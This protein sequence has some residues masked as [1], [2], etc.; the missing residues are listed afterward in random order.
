MS[1]FLRPIPSWQATSAFV[2]VCASAPDIDSDCRRH[3]SLSVALNGL[4][5]DHP[6][7]CPPQ[8]NASHGSM[9]LPAAGWFGVRRHRLLAP[10][11]VGRGHAYPLRLRTADLLNVFATRPEIALLALGALVAVVMSALEALDA[12]GHWL[13]FE[14]VSC[15]VAPAVAAV[16]VGIAARRGEREW[17]SFRIAIAASMALTATGQVIADLPD[18]GLTISALAPVSNLCNVGGAIIGVVTLVAT[19]GLSVPRE[20]RRSVVLD[21]LVILAASMTFVFANWIHQSLLPGG[22][23]VGAEFTNPTANLFLPILSTLFLA[24]A[25][26]SV[27]AALSMRVDPAYRGVWALA[28][29]ILLVALAWQGW[30]GRLISNQPDS[31]EIMDF[32]LPAGSILIGYGAAT[33]SLQPGGGRRYERIAGTIQDWLPIVAIVGCALLDVMPRSRPLALD[34]IAVGT[35]VV[36]LLA[37]GRYRLVLGKQRYATDRLATEQRER[38]ATTV[39]LLSLE[40]APTIE[41]TAERICTEAL[42]IEGIDT[43]VVFVFIGESVVPLALGGPAGRPCEVGVPLPDAA[44]CE[45][46]ECA[47]LGLWIESWVDREPRNDWDRA[48]ALSG[49]RAEAAVAMRW[50]D[51]LIGLLAMGATTPNHASHLQE[52]SPTLTEFSV[53]SAKLLGPALVE[54]TGRETVQ[55]EIKSIIADRKFHP[56]FQP[57]VE[58]ASG[59]HVG[60]EALARFDDGSRPDL[61]FQAADRVGMMV[62]LETAVLREQVLRARDLPEGTFVT[63]N[64][65]PTLAMAVIPLL[66]VLS[67]L[68]RPVVLEVTEHT[69]IKDYGRLAQALD[70]VRPIAGLAVDDAGA[71]YAG[72]RHIL[73]LRPQYVKLD[74]SLVRNVDADPARQAMVTGMAFFAENAGCALIAEGIETVNE[75]TALRL[76]GVQYGQGFY[77]GKP[78]PKW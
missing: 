20:S 71:G 64:I 41:E 59:K 44:A 61:R 75:L 5:H 46:R 27:M 68:D 78:A 28:S 48:I 57:I 15:V 69:E 77:L 22:S 14:D 42:R 21:G 35:C 56:V 34:P 3:A 66:D 23:Q 67:D 1:A 65:S 47:E 55:A 76:L 8:R 53:M 54:R 6:L 9:N 25:A 39:S 11:A 10:A 13:F 52:R 31:I 33:W 7:H 18:A 24:T 17:R 45:L 63:L 2:A 37:V 72:L 74:I 32:L 26:A 62:Q 38:T 4:D 36:V 50:N 19:I 12:G 58:L 40:A 30:I 70:S 16:A 51:D 73:E 49:L 43:V 60:F 29:G